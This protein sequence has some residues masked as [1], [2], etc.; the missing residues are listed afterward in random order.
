MPEPYPPLARQPR[1]M[2]C[3]LQ[4]LPGT[5]TIPFCTLQ[6]NIIDDPTPAP[7][8]GYVSGPQGAFAPLGCP[9]S[10]A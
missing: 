8:G 4:E 9:A 2:R 1:G 7:N 10:P 3:R 5:Q 6:R